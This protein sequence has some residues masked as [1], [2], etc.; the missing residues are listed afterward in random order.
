MM[1]KNIAKWYQGCGVYM[2]SAEKYEQR[3]KG[4]YDY[5][6]KG[7]ACSVCCELVKCFMGMPYDSQELS[8]F[9]SIFNEMDISFSENNVKEIPLLAGMCL[10]NYVLLGEGDDVGVMVSLACERGKQPYQKEIYELIMQNFE[11]RRIEVRETAECSDVKVGALKKVSDEEKA[12][13]TEGVNYVTSALTEQNKNIKALVSNV[14]ILKGQLRNKSEESNLLWWL[15]AGWSEICDCSLEELS[16]K[17]AAAIIPIEV[18][19]YIE[20]V[21]GPVAV[22]KVM[23]KALQGKEILKEYTVKE[24]IECIHKEVLLDEEFAN[25]EL[26]TYIGFTPLLELLKNRKRFPKEDDL[27]T[28]YKLY[29]EKYDVAFLEEKYTVIGLANQIYLECELMEMWQR[30]ISYGR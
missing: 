18:M 4:I 21:P 19:Q 24:Y 3:L 2:D 30:G 10:L 27:P 12:D 23:R 17:Q 14:N 20:T 11:N 25:Y 28:V 6:E 8:E 16:D 26:T 7:L 1:E 9:V 15:I 5:T 13:W 22:K 29:G